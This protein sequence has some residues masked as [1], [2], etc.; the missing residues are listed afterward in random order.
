MDIV[1]A[2]TFSSMAFSA[3]LVMGTANR[4]KMRRIRDNLHAVGREVGRQ[5]RKSDREATEARADRAEIKDRLDRIE[6]THTV[7]QAARAAQ[8]PARHTLRADRLRAAR[9]APR[10]DRNGRSA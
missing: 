6:R 4:G 5:S 8:G 9:Q 3:V 10:P 2:A 1:N 7:A